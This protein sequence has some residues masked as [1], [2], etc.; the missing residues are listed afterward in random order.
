VKRGASRRTRG[1]R[2]AAL[3]GLFPDAY[4]GLER[5]KRLE[6]RLARARLKNRRQPELTRAIQIEA[7]A[8]RKTLDREQAA[9]TR[10]KTLDR[11]QAAA[12]REKT[13][14]REQAAATRESKPAFG[15]DP[16]SPAA[17]QTTDA[18]PAKG[19]RKNPHGHASPTHAGRR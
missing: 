5:I 17:R 18:A 11:E 13:L 2:A 19:A 4:A 14:D 8:Y 10:E 3:P 15:L 16:V 9:A 1:G 6:Q 7:H 12:T